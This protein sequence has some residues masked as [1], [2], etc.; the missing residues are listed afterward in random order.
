M[1][2]DSTI[3]AKSFFKVI[4]RLRDQLLSH[5]RVS[6]VTTGDLSEVDLAKQTIFPLAHIIV[7]QANFNSTVINYDVSVLIMDT[8]LQD[9]RT[10]GGEEPTIYQGDNE[11]YVLNTCINVGN[12]L[13]D[14]L[15][16]GSLYDGN[17]YVERSSVVAEP[18]RDRFENLV[19]G[20]SFNF[21]ITVRNNIDRCN[22]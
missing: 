20:W 11:L 18:F 15:F 5:P 14:A 8:V 16:N 21:T 4:E 13:T 10:V 9:V 1:A 6:T 19:A 17:T 2:V 3:G 22:S 7:T 12:H